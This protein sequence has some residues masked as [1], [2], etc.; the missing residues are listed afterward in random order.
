MSKP[1]DQVEEVNEE[2][3]E[4]MKDGFG[5]KEKESDPKGSGPQEKKRGGKVK[6]ARGGAM[7]LDA[8]DEHKKKM[9]H[10]HPRKRGGKV[11]GKASKSRPDR[12][13]RGGGLAD[14]NPTTAAGNVSVPDYE[15]KSAYENGGG[16]GGDMSPYKGG[17]HR[18]PG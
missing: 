16:K 2:E 4:A 13:A 7:D 6:R 12:R 11:P 5:A 3:N 14:M 17:G 1:F 18:R 9:P 15:K 8:A 10:H